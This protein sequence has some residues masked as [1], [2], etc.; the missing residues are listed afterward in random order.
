MQVVIWGPVQSGSGEAITSCQSSSTLSGGP[1]EDGV[2]PRPIE[3]ARA[4]VATTVTAIIGFVRMID[5]LWVLGSSRCW[6]ISDG[7]SARQ[8]DGDQPA[9]GPRLGGARDAGGIVEQGGLDD[10]V[11]GIALE[12]DAEDPGGLERDHAIP[13]VVAV[14]AVFVVDRDRNRVAD[15]AG[16][17]ALDAGADP[18]VALEGDGRW[19]LSLIELNGA[20]RE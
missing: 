14:P 8:L 15:D 16:Q 18:R 2:C 11:L 4:Q 7:Q 5:L 9:R 3:P 6:P 12:I 20:I 19:A 10:H 13:G 17:D 1:E